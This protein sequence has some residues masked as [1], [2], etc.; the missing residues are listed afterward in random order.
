[1]GKQRIGGRE[2]VGVSSLVPFR[3][4]AMQLAALLEEHQAV[5]DFLRDDV[6]EHVNQIRLGRV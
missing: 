3:R 6:P 4:G 2:I 5:R 1:M